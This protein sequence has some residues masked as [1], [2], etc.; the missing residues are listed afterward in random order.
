MTKNVKVL[1]YVDVDDNTKTMAL[2]FDSE[3]DLRDKE[4]IKKAA[5]ALEVAGFGSSF[6][7]ETIAW[8][9]I[10]HG[11]AIL[12]CTMGKYEFGFEEVELISF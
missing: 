12:N 5:E 7:C 11:S 8:E 6:V 1:F 9:V 4:H 3:L 10:Y 2:A